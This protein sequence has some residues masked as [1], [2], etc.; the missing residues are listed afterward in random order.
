VDSYD[1]LA[2]PR[3]IDLQQ[4][5]AQQQQQARDQSFWLGRLRQ[6]AE[7][8]A[9]ADDFPAYLLAQTPFAGLAARLQP[10]R[11]RVDGEDVFSERHAATSRR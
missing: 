2:D 7:G 1:F 10:A 6:L 4:R 9:L 8:E 11:A 3:A 5:R